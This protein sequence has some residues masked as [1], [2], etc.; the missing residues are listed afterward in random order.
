MDILDAARGGQNVLERLM[1][2]LP[3]FR[4]YR[5]KELRRDAATTALEVQ[6]A[7]RN[8]SVRLRGRVP[9]LV[10]AE[11]VEAVAARVPGVV[12]VIEELDLQSA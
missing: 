3:G 5:E 9:D 10:D 2:L 6:V 4:G 8:G 12:E 1:N 11:N 7:V